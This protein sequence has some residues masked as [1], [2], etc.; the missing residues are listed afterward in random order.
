M[1]PHPAMRLSALENARGG[2]PAAAVEH[3]WSG[4]HRLS[5]RYFAACVLASLM[6]FYERKVRNGSFVR[7]LKSIAA[8]IKRTADKQLNKYLSTV[9]SKP[10]DCPWRQTAR[11]PG[12]TVLDGKSRLVQVSKNH[13]KK[14]PTMVRKLRSGIFSLSLA[15]G[16]KPFLPGH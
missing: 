2:L 9:I 5:P 16:T 3:T 6:H 4:V 7:Q 14:A 1:L 15:A 13:A 11:V 8:R 10:L 12:G